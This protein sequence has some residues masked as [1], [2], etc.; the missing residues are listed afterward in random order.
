MSPL[1]QQGATSTHVTL[2][3]EREL[4]TVPALGPAEGPAI[5][6]PLTAKAT[7]QDE[8]SQV[9]IKGLIM[10]LGSVYMPQC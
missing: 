3:H 4:S 7:K 5:H 6:L 2:L 1:S 9:L 10:T 8:R